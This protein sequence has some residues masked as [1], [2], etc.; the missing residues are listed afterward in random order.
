MKSIKP[1]LL[2]SYSDWKSSSRSNKRCPLYEKPRSLW[3]YRLYSSCS[4]Q[5]GKY[6]WVFK[7][8]QVLAELDEMQSLYPQLITVKAPISTYTTAQNRPIY[9]VKISDILI[10]TKQNPKHYTLRFIT[11]AN[12]VHYRL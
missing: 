7:L 9:W 5:F 8:T 2:T 6:G 4:F 11:L 12:L 1:K 3:F 10:R